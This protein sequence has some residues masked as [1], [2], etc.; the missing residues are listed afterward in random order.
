[1]LQ[2]YV[3][4]KF[5]TK[6]INKP[7]KLMDDG[8]YKIFLKPRIIAVVVLGSMLSKQK[9]FSNGLEHSKSICLYITYPTDKLLYLCHY[10]W[11]KD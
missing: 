4:I 8:V 3:A 11:S 7:N 6:C 10:W 2:S 1:M 9:I 5:R